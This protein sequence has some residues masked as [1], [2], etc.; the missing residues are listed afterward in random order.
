[1]NDIKH[2][3]SFPSSNSDSEPV[4]LTL[5]N[6]RE[7]PVQPF[8]SKTF[9]LVDDL[10]VDSVISWGNTGG[11]I[12]VWD[13]VEFA[14][15]LLPRHFKHNNFAS[16]VRQLNAYGF[17]KIDTDKWEFANENFLRG[18][19]HL[20]KNIHRRKSTHCQQAEN[21]SSELRK[22]KV[23]G[24]IELL[25][26]ERG[27][28]MQ[29]VMELQ[30]QHR[31]TI[32]H[33]EAVNE[34]LQAAEQKQKQTVS[35]LVN[36]F[37]KPEF[38]AHLQPK[39]HGSI[40]SPRTAKKFVKHQETKPLMLASALEKQIVKFLDNLES[41][42]TTCGNAHLNPMAAEQVVHSSKKDTVESPD[43]G[44]EVPKCRLQSVVS[45]V[46][47]MSPGFEEF[48]GQGPWNLGFEAGPSIS[49]SNP[50][51]WGN[52]SNNIAPEFGVSGGM[53]A[54]IEKSAKFDC[55][56]VEKGSVAQ[57]I[58]SGHSACVNYISK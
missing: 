42:A 48:K 3:F 56:A 10:T 14:R 23:K 29:E 31:D 47:L 28:M 45:S 17:R 46:S 36:V 33:M 52:L 30:Q 39:D 11:S 34:K 41:S 1:M 54:K 21:P 51:V 24:E 49:N 7:N 5:R 40:L 22:A 55:L 8:L 58:C 50:V 6:L 25:S 9:D 16:F 53:Y 2:I 57:F 19:R 27:M 12:V 26:K 37:Q 20:L 32:Q 15:L 43:L 44:A 13:P 38:L 35:F 18:K 4:A